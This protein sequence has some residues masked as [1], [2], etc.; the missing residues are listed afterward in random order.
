MN[1]RHFLAAIA[2]AA[3]MVAVPRYGA[4]F[5]ARPA[6]SIITLPPIVTPFGE[7]GAIDPTTLRHILPKLLAEGL[8]QLRQE[9]VPRR[10]LTSDLDA[11]ILGT[12]P[13]RAHEVTG[14]SWDVVTA[15]LLARRP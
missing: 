1:R 6:R 4:W 5:R 8:L 11:L 15:R 9:V 14:V 12:R 7:P 2:G 3:G 10:L 13:P